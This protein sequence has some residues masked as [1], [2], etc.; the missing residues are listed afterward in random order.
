VASLVIER[1]HIRRPPPH[2]LD[3]E[4]RNSIPSSLD[5][6]SKLLTIA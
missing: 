5:P 4:A 6:S 2:S 3:Q 1:S